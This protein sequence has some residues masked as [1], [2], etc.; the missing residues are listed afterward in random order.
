MNENIKFLIRV[1]FFFGQ[2]V[3]RFLRKSIF[4]VAMCAGAPILSK[5][6]INY[7]P[8]GFF[9]GL[10]LQGYL[11]PKNV[12]VNTKLESDSRIRE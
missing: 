8:V 3:P 1:R 5:V 6:V 4:N 10:I 2:N 12:T 9:R 7:S 11:Y